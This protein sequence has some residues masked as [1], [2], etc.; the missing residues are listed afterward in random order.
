MK[1]IR[2]TTLRALFISSFAALSLGASSAEAANPQ[3]LLIAPG[4]PNGPGFFLPK[5]GFS[6]FTIN[7]FGERVTHVRYNSRAARMGLEP[8]DVILSLNGYALTYHGAWNDALR[9][10]IYNGAS[11]IRLRIRDV[12][13]GKVFFRETYLDNCGYG[14]VTPKYQVNYGPGPGNPYVAHHPGNGTS[15]VKNIAELIKALKD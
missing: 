11:R 9:T 8:G 4:E 15:T 1:T 12:N 14:P 13:T 2:N 3:P 6:S 7:G 5:F 10:A